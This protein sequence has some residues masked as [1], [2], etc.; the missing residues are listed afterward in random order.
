MQE[1]GHKVGETLSLTTEQLK[2]KMCLG[3]PL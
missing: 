2:Q 1:L 3:E